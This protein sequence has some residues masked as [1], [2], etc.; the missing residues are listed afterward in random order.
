MNC[1]D[2]TEVHLFPYLAID[3]LDADGVAGHDAILLSPGLNNGVHLSSKRLKQTLIIGFPAQTVKERLT[4][5]TQDC[6]ILCYA[7]M[8]IIW[9][10]W[11]PSLVSPEILTWGK[12]DSRSMPLVKMR[13]AISCGMV[14]SESLSPSGSSVSCQACSARERYQLPPHSPETLI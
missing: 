7:T 13:H 4:Q 3:P 2:G 5:L 1:Q 11:R 10:A 9:S 14:V 8:E 12:A 6:A